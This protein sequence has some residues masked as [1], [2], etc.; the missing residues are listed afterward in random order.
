MKNL[1][2]LC[3]LSQNESV[4]SENGTYKFSVR[5]KGA[6]PETVKFC[7]ELNIEIEDEI[8]L[9][10]SLLGLYRGLAYRAP[11]LYL[12]TEDGGI[13]SLIANDDC[14]TDGRR[15][16][17]SA[18]VPSGKYSYLTV[19]LS[20]DRAKLCEL[21][22][23][24]L[25]TCKSE[26]LPICLS[27]FSRDVIEGISPI[28]ISGLLNG[29]FDTDSYGVKIGGGRIFDR[30]E[31]SP[32]GIPFRVKAEGYNAVIPPP[33]PK[34]NE[35]I[36]DNFGV[37]AMRKVCRPISRDSKTEIAIGKAVSEIYFILG[38]SGERYQRYT[39]AT[40]GN[41]LG[42]YGK[43]VTEPLRVDD[44]EG[45]YAEIKYADGH[46]D[47]ALPKN[48]SENRF[49][50]SGDVSV[51]AIA[52][53]FKEVESVVFHNKKLDTDFS[54]LAVS[55][56]GNEIG[57]YPEL[58]IPEYEK[59]G[60]KNCSSEKNV[61][62][63]GNVLKIR[64]GAIYAEFDLSERL[65]L[66]FLGCDFAGVIKASSESLVRFNYSESDELIMP[67]VRSVNI[68]E[69]G[70]VITL[71]SGELEFFVDI[72]INEENNLV[73]LLKVNNNS[74]KDEKIGVLFPC[75]DNVVSK[76]NSDLY[77]F[78][79]KYQNVDSNETI[80]VSEESSP[81]FP[82][83]FMSLYSASE[84]GGLGLLTRER[85]TVVRI[86]HLEKRDGKASF[87][88][89][90]PDMYSNIKS[91]ESFT[92]SE[93][94]IMACRD[95][96]RDAMRAYKSW[97]N[98]WYVPYKC[99]NKQWYRECF[100]LLAEITDFFERYDFVRF[101]IW[102]EKGENPKFNFLDILE[103]QK[104]ISGTY[105]DILHMW[106]WTVRYDENGKKC[107]KW[108]NWGGEDYELY[109]GLA[110][111]RR[112]LDEFQEKTG[113]YSSIYMH[114]TLFAQIYP[115]FKKYEHLKVVNSEGKN[116]QLADSFRMC[117]ANSDWR[118][119]ALDKYPRVYS[120]L[121]V[122][123]LYVDE[124]SLR[125]ENRCY[126]DGHGHEVPSNLLKTDKEFISRLKDTVPEEL[127]LYGEYAAVDMNARYIDC[128]ITYGILDSI[129]EMIERSWRAADSDLSLGRVM[130]DAY[131]F[132]FPGIVQLV[133]PMALRNLSWHPHK[134]I[135]WNGEAE[136]D[137]FWDV[138]E[139]D[140]NEFTCKAYAIKKKYADCFSS[141]FPE[142]MI[143]TASPA[144]CIN[145]FPG[146]GRCVYTV[147]NRAYRTYRGKVLCIPHTDGNAY[148]DVWNGKELSVITEN[149]YATV[150][151]E[152]DAQSIGCI[153]VYNSKTEKIQ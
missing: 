131:R 84:F 21:S 124:F 127:V 50:V 83:Q 27:A 103:E 60:V 110:R 18:S 79:P 52:C 82:M 73:T 17:L 129:T 58:S 100:W 4:V 148:Y 104:K 112:A 142:M 54:L 97:L 136:Y 24:K 91:G 117:H 46:R 149:G 150:E 5:R 152:I 61:S 8:A 85:D 128:N 16:T 115:D 37:K 107:V 47:K 63:D 77:Y 114:P 109:G 38:M 53:D 90:Y 40:K 126:A 98:S 9:E 20:V 141:D 41:I 116:I 145:K 56:N 26:E 15:Y 78:V 49:S 76:D 39:F 19:E 44:V 33:P 134:F 101:P 35:D 108:G 96:K 29:R 122:P 118:Q 143:E 42:T 48:L 99:Q 113:V 135:F 55:V 57:C 43:E 67:V 69:A 106:H 86:Y 140:G 130:T 68:S 30:E 119:Y 121:G 45:F 138:L 87:F 32:F 7:A 6:E 62:L 36:I 12:T 14:N 28:D 59:V 92:A 71:E 2:K 81:S 111:F 65:R 137:S 22:V 123:I 66:S 72:S 105:P 13:V 51:Y 74:Q 3:F 95:G 153:L 23:Y 11:L 125:I 34:E 120:E 80:V 147:Y 70:A 94:V 89:E 151:L 10:Y 64:N 88:V 25:Y 146:K 139:S 93:S 31:I 75:L 144:I 102:H 133:L 132:A 1:T